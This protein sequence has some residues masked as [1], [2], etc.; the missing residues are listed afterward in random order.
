MA[1]RKFDIG[2]QGRS[3]KIGLWKR[4]G[5]PGGFVFGPAIFCHLACGSPNKDRI[6]PCV[7]RRT[8]CV[9]RILQPKRELVNF[10]NS[11]GS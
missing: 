6:F 4:D 5:R 7:W 1:H 8:A 10:L 11:A 3:C 9:C 2:R